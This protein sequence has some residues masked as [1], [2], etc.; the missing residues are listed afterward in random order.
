MKTRLNIRGPLR[1]FRS[2]GAAGRRRV[3]QREK[4]REG[5]RE[6]GRS[7][8][9]D[10]NS[11]AALGDIWENI[12]PPE[13]GERF[14][15]SGPRARRALKTRLSW[16]RARSTMW[17]KRLNFPKV[18]LPAEELIGRTDEQ[19][20]GFGRRAERCKTNLY[21]YTRESGIPKF[22]S[23]LADMKIQ[24]NSTDF[25]ALGLVSVIIEM[26]AVSLAGSPPWKC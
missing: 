24:V 2:E 17:T 1:N 3:K 5:G 13:C 10:G 8:E 4:R 22:V 6:G 25:E 16:A 12:F 7:R 21:I 11:L 9:L 20:R 18:Y 14:R 19:K 26:T 15:V 23:S